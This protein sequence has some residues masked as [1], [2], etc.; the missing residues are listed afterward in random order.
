M[1]IRGGTVVTG[2]G[3]TVI[4]EGFVLVRS[5]VI[6]D[7][8]SGPGPT[9]SEDEVLDAT[10]QL[11]C[12]GFINGHAH[13]CIPGPFAPAA[14][15]PLP[16]EEVRANLDR[17]LVAGETTILNLCGF[18][19]E[20]ELDR[21]RDHPARVYAATT[22][23][24]ACLRVAR[25]FDGRG[26]TPAHELRTVE[27][28]LAEGA[29]AIGEI[30]SGQVL[31]GGAQDYRHIPDAIEQVSGV[32]LQA[33]QARELKWA[34]LGRYVQPGAFDP[35][36]TADL[37]RTLGLA[38][39]LTPDEARR[40]VEGSVLPP[41]GEALK[42]FEEAAQLAERTGRAAIFH[43]G[44]ASI[45]EI[46]RLAERY[47]RA[48]LVA[49]H[50][51]GADFPPDENLEWCRRLRARGV[52]VDV[53]TWDSPGR[54]I[55]AD[56][57]KFV[58][59]LAAGV[60]DTVSTDFGGGAWEPIVKGL[61]MAVRAQALTISAAVALATGNVARCLPELAGDRGLLS[62]GKLADL[63]C[64][65]RDDLAQVRTVVVAGR[66]VVRDGRRLS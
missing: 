29:V 53:S 49:G 2:D 32:R 20:E 44:T 16:M 65:D 26:L 58:A 63:L 4:P 45:E 60:V 52:V 31:G 43:T 8:G 15:V 25:L 47:P 23:A 30:G 19:L 66:V 46:I 27:Q 39:R 7:V 55:Q 56:P 10:G 5:G 3:R 34:V 54:A 17:H 11:V 24:P 12:P 64:T 57:K 40:A 36:R 18:C 37:L 62:R 50:S 41:L 48:R 38:G 13:A 59:L 1:L 14:G 42:S 51:N 33:D 35:A 28:R 9:G 61:A 21:V 6:A 22:H